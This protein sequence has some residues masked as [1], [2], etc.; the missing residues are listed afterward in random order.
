MYN[1]GGFKWRTPNQKELALML[2]NVTNITGSDYGTR[3]RFSGDDIYNTN[4]WSWHDTPGF[5]SD[6]GRINVGVG[7]STSNTQLSNQS[8]V[9]VRC[10]R[11]ILSAA[12]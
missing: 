4:Y 1:E 5:W 8:N 9:K 6:N 11:D 2:S 7:T 3:T 10:V 12:Q